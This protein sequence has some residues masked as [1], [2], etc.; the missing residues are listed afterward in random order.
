MEDNKP[1]QQTTIAKDNVQ[2]DRMLI[3]WTSV[4]KRKLVVTMFEV[5]FDLSCRVDN[6]FCGNILWRSFLVSCHRRIV[7]RTYSILF[8]AKIVYCCA[9]WRY[10][11]LKQVGHRLEP[12]GMPF[13]CMFSLSCCGSV[14]LRASTCSLPSSSLVLI[15]LFILFFFVFNTRATTPRLIASNKI[16]IFTISVSMHFLCRFRNHNG[17]RAEKVSSQKFS[18]A[19]FPILFVTRVSS[20]WQL[21]PSI[22]FVFVCRS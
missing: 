8:S 6:S 1:T 14:N 20:R 17:S 21:L 18:L 4:L 9:A 10:L 3:L 7:F 22:F 2:H 12:R 19:Q 13:S 15:K 5:Y 11:L 16:R